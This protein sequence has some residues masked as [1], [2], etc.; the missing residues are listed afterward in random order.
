MHTKRRFVS[1]RCMLIFSKS[2]EVFNIK[3]SYMRKLR[4]IDRVIGK[5]FTYRLKYFFI[6]VFHLCSFLEKLK[7]FFR[8]VLYFFLL[9][10]LFSTFFV[11]IFVGF[12]IKRV[13]INRK[14]WLRWSKKLTAKYKQLIT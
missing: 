3:N 14:K 10:V 4:F 12:S 13:L 11:V 5:M 9:F 7:C 8:F 6:I 2:C 1:E